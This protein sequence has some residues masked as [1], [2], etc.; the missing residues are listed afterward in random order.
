MAIFNSYVK[1]PEG[2][3]QSWDC[4]IKFQ[5]LTITCSLFFVGLMGRSMP[6]RSRYTG[7]SENG[8]TWG[9]PICHGLENHAPRQ[10][11]IN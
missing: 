7:V 5:D 10:N 6:N 2:N 11:A 1:L 3:T 8:V 4:E 9:N